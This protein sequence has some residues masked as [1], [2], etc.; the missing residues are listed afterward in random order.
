MDYS[1][2]R[3]GLLRF[4]PA[5]DQQREWRLD[6]DAMGSEMFYTDPPPYD[7]VIRSLTAFQD[8]LN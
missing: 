6:Y 5:G 2:E 4:V 7:D 3:R 1:A 8:R